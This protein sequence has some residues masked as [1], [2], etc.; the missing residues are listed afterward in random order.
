MEKT[1]VLLANG[2]RARCFERQ[3]ADHSLTELNDF[4]YPH[5]SLSGL[6]GGGDLTGAAGKGHGRTGHAGTQFEPRTEAQDKA[7]TST[8]NVRA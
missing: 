5:A 3:A 4:V 2:E 7:V 6:A 8:S 1:W